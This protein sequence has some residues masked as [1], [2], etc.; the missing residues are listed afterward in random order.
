MAADLSARLGR[1][2]GDDVKRVEKLVAGAN[3]PIRAPHELSADRML[4]LM[5]VDKKI[6]DGKLRVVL[7]D[8]IGETKLDG[9]FDR[10][11]LKETL[12]ECREA[13]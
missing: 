2:D 5:A 8:A 12:E 4:E 11:A 13:A 10:G 9:D 3:L 6:K 7:L 1:I